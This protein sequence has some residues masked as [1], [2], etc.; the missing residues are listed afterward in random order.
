[1]QKNEA[2]QS[3]T[4]EMNAKELGMLI[5]SLDSANKVNTYSILYIEVYIAITFC[6]ISSNTQNIL[7]VN[8]QDILQTLNI[9]TE[10]IACSIHPFNCQGT[11]NEPTQA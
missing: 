5:S 10:S 4:V 9:Y 8:I 11:Q 1:M 2:L 6:N 7:Y 3:V